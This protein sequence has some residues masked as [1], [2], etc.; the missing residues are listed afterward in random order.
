MNKFKQFLVLVLFLTPGLCSRG[1]CPPG[2]D[3]FLVY[4]VDLKNQNIKFFWRDD[5]NQPFRTFENLSSWLRKKGQKLVFATNGGMYKTDRAP[6]GL[7]I[8]SGK[9]IVRVNRATASG[10]F[11]LKPN[12]VFYITKNNIGAI[13]VT[14][15][16]K[17]GTNVQYATQSGP[18]LV[19]DGK[20][21]PEFKRGSSN[22]KIRNGVGILSNGQILFAMAKQPINLYD[23]ANFFL[24]SGC[25]SAL[26]L[27][28]FVSRTY[29]PSQN[30]KQTGGNFG[31]IIAEISSTK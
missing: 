12:G 8:D 15:K 4:C 14:E 16:F 9:T 18:M 29:L 10:N 23:F 31:V 22:A 27:D 28:G 3:S 30:W 13:T 11:Y 24:I 21:H 1:Q 7:Y 19:V 17:P 20:I 6:L 25:K 2:N 26:Y 5:S